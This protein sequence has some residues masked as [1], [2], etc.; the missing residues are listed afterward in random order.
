MQLRHSSAANYCRGNMNVR[1]LL[2][3]LATASTSSYADAP[4]VAGQA[5]AIP[6]TKGGFDFLE[7][8]GTNHR[9]LADHTGNGSLDVIDLADGK[10]IKSI[11]TGSAQGVAVDEAGGKYYVSV[12]KQKKFVIVDRET[13]AVTG[14]VALGGPADA[15]TFDPRNGCAYV[16]HDDE[17]E[18]WV[19]DV[20]TAIGAKTLAVA[21]DAATHA[22]WTA[23]AEGTSAY[24]LKLDAGK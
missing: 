7:I 21:V 9:L 12:S 18:L 16:G 24:V 11:P 23:Y 2:A 17:K 3:V 4:L 5:V 20:K 8:D 22:V 1:I 13:L 19:V 15:L 14:E 6:G 10:L